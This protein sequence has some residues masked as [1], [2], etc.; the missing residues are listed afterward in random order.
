MKRKLRDLYYYYSFFF[1][2]RKLRKKFPF[3]KIQSIQETAEDIINNKKSIS[4][5]GD[6]EFRQILADSDISFQNGNPRLT[7]LL[8]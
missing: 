2:T 6:G 4:R 8:R 5:F 3:Y 1:K 7:A